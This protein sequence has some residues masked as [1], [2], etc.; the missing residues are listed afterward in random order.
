MPQIRRHYIAIAPRALRVDLDAPWLRHLRANVHRDSNG[1]LIL[2]HEPP[3]PLSRV[4]PMEGGTAQLALLET[5]RQRLEWLAGIGGLQLRCAWATKTGTSDVFGQFLPHAYASVPEVAWIEA[6]LG[7]RA[8]VQRRPPVHEH[9]LDAEAPP[10]IHRLADA[11]KDCVTMLQSH[12]DGASPSHTLESANHVLAEFNKAIGELDRWSD[13]DPLN[14]RRLRVLGNLE[15]LVRSAQ[16]KAVG[17]GNSEHAATLANI[18][19]HLTL[20]RGEHAA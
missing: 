3:R 9:P 1:T 11:L 20:L 16:R 14:Q 8:L 18:S 15:A 17:S 7:A 5:E 4:L 12:R 13:R 10:L 6:R 2:F 19:T